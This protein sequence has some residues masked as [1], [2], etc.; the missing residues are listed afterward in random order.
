MGEACENCDVPGEKVSV[1]IKPKVVKV[2][3]AGKK[4]KR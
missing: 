2:G 3:K 4:G 1:S